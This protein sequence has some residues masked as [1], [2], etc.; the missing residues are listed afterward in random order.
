MAKNRLLLV[1]RYAEQSARNDRL[2]AS[3][4]P[5]TATF[6]RPSRAPR[7]AGIVAVI[8]AYF[9]TSPKY[10]GLPPSLISVPEISNEDSFNDREYWG[11]LDVVEL[12]A[13]FN[14]LDL[15]QQLGAP[16]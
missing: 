2:N 15:L 4:C 7:A 14:V 13:Q 3:R 6:D 16:V 8:A 11:H 12:S 9:W 1:I 10:Q 5:Y